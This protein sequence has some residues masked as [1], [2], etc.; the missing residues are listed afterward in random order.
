MEEQHVAHSNAGMFTT[1]PDTGHM[2]VFGTDG[3]GLS[4]IHI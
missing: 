1:C 2:H 4:L 3:L